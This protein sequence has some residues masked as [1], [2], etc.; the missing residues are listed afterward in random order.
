MLWQIFDN[1]GLKIESLS[2]PCVA[3]LFLSLH[4]IENVA[5]YIAIGSY[6]IESYAD[7]IS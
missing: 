2:L 4:Q 6:D 1:A 3:V 7:G 5:S